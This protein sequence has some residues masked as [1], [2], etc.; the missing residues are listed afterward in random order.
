MNNCIYNSIQ[1]DEVNYYWIKSIDEYNSVDIVND[2]NMELDE[3]SFYNYFEK[4]KGTECIKRLTIHY[5]SQLKNVGIIRFFPNLALLRINGQN[6]KSLDGLEWF[7]NGKSINISLEKHQKCNI[8]K[9][10]LAPIQ[11]LYL[12]RSFS[13]DFE[14]IGKCSSLKT[15]VLN[16]NSAPNFIEW[17]D[18]PIQYLRFSQGK[19]S[20]IQ[21]LGY[22]KSLNRL[23][24]DSCRKFERFSGDNS[25]VKSL[26]IVTCK[27]FDIHSLY[28]LQGIEYVLINDCAKEINF[29]ELPEHRTIRKINLLT[30]KVIF[31]TFHINEKMPQLRNMYIQNITKEQT[32]QLEQVNPNLK[33]DESLS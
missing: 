6:I 15:L 31:D 4:L 17:R 13:K 5:S 16:I 3:G 10:S 23:M 27:H 12:N 32:A 8:E 9:V 19:F 21:N 7:K 26:T 2:S 1:I 14:A 33:I 24:I 25:C 20:E 11:S 29:S 30:C 18:I 28:A 22:L